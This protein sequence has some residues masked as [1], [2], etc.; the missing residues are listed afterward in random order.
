MTG[1]VIMKTINRLKLT[2]LA[3]VI[4]LSTTNAQAA[5]Y[6]R[7]NGMIY[8]SA[9]NIT[10]LQDANYAKTSGYD[11]DGRMTWSQSHTWA[12][13]LVYGGFSDW[14]LSS[15][16]LNGTDMMNCGGSYAVCPG[17]YN[18]TND[19][20]WNNTRSEI[21]HLFLELGNNAVWS[22]T[23]V[24]TRSY[25]PIDMTFVDAATNQNVSFLNLQ[26]YFYWEAE[27]SYLNPNEAWNFVT[28]GG[29]QEPYS[30]KSSP[31]HAW[32]VR[33]GDVTA[34]PVPASAW[35]M[36]SGLIGLAGL[37]KRKKV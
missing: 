28:D 26:K 20:G 35:L 34:V 1:D 15:A 31:F 17:Y 6:N 22:T 27:T 21:G 11:A 2:A 37:A 3:T 33:D 12:N 32:A 19:L 18:G 8:D 14:R 5:L 4:A 29:Y 16:R 7:G 9:L 23:G 25:A 13:N 30:G 36:G 10:W 24:S